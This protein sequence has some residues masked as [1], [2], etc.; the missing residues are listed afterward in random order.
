VTFYGSAAATPTPSPAPSVSV[1]IKVVQLHTTSAPSSAPLVVAII[2]V[3]LSVAALGW[4]AYTFWRAGH[5]VRVQLNAGAVG[6]GNLMSFSRS[7]FPT[8]TEMAQMAKQGFTAPILVAVIRN[9]GRQAVTVQQCNWAAGPVTLS[10]PSSPF[11]DTFPRRLE[12]GDSCKAVIPLAM[13]T[14]ALGANAAVL[15]SP[16]RQVAAVVDLGTGKTVRSKKLEIPPEANPKTPAGN[17]GG[18]SAR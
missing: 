9:D 14:V 3:V 11:G 10:L 1:I 5:R 15:K 13:V 7:K 18:Q 12:A 17:S 2:G 6:P 4:Q 16:A 8:A